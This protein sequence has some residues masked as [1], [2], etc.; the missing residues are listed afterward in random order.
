ARA[1]RQRR[2]RRRRRRGVPAAPRRR[3]R[4]ADG[5]REAEDREVEND[6]EKARETELTMVKFTLN[7]QEQTVDVEPDTPLLWVLRETLGMT[8]TKF[9]CGMALCG[10]CTIH[11]DG[12]ATRSCMLPVGEVEGAQVT[13]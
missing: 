9:G 13:T 10:A 2:S 3:G 8:G 5:A 11:L 7:G 12:V 4:E 6:Q 1:R